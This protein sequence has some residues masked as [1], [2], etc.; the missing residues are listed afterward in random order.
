MK[1]INTSPNEQLDN[2]NDIIKEL[3][4]DHNY[5][6]MHLSR[7]KGWLQSFKYVPIEAEEPLNHKL[8][9]QSLHIHQL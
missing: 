9:E 3:A 5:K 8:R 2:L 6:T 7:T 4:N 1:Q